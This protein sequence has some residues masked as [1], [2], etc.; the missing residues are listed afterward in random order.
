MASKAA[1][2]GRYYPLSPHIDTSRVFRRGKRSTCLLKSNRLVI[3]AEGVTVVFER[4]FTFDAA[5]IP[6]KG[7]RDTFLPEAGATEVLGI[8]EN[9]F[10][11]A[12]LELTP[13]SRILMIPFA[14][15][16]ARWVLFG[17]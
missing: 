13:G 6:T 5:Q 12:D 8:R 10:G 4:K 3:R 14:R 9:T 1:A 7:D 11:P 16:C 15:T 2:P 17:F